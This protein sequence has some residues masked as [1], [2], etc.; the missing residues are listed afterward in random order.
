M[1]TLAPWDTISVFYSAKQSQYLIL[2]GQHSHNIQ[3]LS[4]GDS[5]NIRFLLDFI[6]INI[7][8]LVNMCIESCPLAEWLDL[9]APTHGPGCGSHSVTPTPASPSLPRFVSQRSC[10]YFV[11]LICFC[12]NNFSPEDGAEHLFLRLSYEGSHVEPHWVGEEGGV[13]AHLGSIQLNFNR[14]FNWLF[15]WVLLV[16]LWVPQGLNSIEYW[17]ILYIIFIFLL[18]FTGCRT[19]LQNSIEEVNNK[20]FNIRLNR[21]PVLAKL[22]WKGNW[23]VRWNLNWIDPWL[24]RRPGSATVMKL[25]LHSLRCIP[26]AVVV[27]DVVDDDDVLI[28]VVVGIE[29]ADAVL[30]ELGVLVVT[31]KPCSITLRTFCI[32]VAMVIAR[33]ED[34]ITI[35]ETNPRRSV[36]K[37]WR[38]ISLSVLVSIALKSTQHIVFSVITNYY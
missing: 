36:F 38:R 25:F 2:T 14:I 30:F 5:H 12:F 23:K 28:A 8:K 24:P 20:V 29:V 1:I 3:F 4:Q 16:L 37:I 18:S 6:T 33:G 35:T 15:S 32:M 17:K 9:W 22:N 7:F 26:I 10:K 27:V 34:T 13:L 21:A 11:K 31:G 19:V